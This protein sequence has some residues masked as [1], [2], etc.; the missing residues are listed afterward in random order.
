MSVDD[1]LLN[2]S[3]TI[4]PHP[5]LHKNPLADASHLWQRPDAD[6]MPALANAP[7][8]DALNNWFTAITS[9]ALHSPCFRDNIATCRAT[10]GDDQTV[11]NALL[12][13]SKSNTYNIQPAAIN[14]DDDVALYTERLPL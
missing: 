12:E 7:N 4:V 2:A 9:P 14:G 5:L 8:M 6:N 3:R 1:D 13:P 10:D 11:S